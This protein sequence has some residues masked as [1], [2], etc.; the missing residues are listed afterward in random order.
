MERKPIS[1][2]EA[3]RIAQLLMQRHAAH[4]ADDEWLEVEG[5]RSKEEV[6]T[7]MILR[8]EDE[9]LF[10]PVECRMDLTRN[11]VAGPIAAQDVLL[12]FQDQYFE[13]FFQENR[14][15]YLTIDWSDL[16]FAQYTIQAKGQILNKKLDDLTDQFLAGEIHA[17]EVVQKGRRKPASEE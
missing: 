11:P 15:L 3:Q 5:Y 14:D 4:L 1:E 12:D 10:Y 2:F 7:C 6:Y 17:D 16:E 8:N 13:Q 9:S